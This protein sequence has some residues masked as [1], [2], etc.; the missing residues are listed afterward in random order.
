ML[1]INSGGGRNMF[2]GTLVGFIF[3]YLIYYLV[4]ASLNA[5]IGGIGGHNS[6]SDDAL[7]EAKGGDE[8]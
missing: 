2:F 1:N 6:A 3:L 7:N 5:L 8:L 4:S